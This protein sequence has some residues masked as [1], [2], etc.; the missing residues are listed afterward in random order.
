MRPVKLLPLLL[1]TA[2]LLPVTTLCR[3][4]P[5]NGNQ[6]Q[7]AMALLAKMDQLA[8]KQA[9]QVI[10]WRRDIHQHP[11]LGNR[12]F[13]TAEKIAAHLRSL[14]I[15]VKIGVGK[16]GVIG[17]LKGGH[18]GPVVALRADMDAL[19]I[20]E[21][22]ELAFKSVV[23]TGYNGQTTGVMHACGHDTHVA[24]LMG[25]A[26]IL[27][28]VK[29]DLRGSVKFIFQPCEEGPPAGEEGGAKL[30]VKEAALEN[31]AVDVIFG[32]H[33]A[34]GTPTGTFI[35]KPGSVSAENDIFRIVIKGKQSHGASPWLGVDPIVTGSQ[36]V[37]ALQTIVSRN[38]PLTSNAA[39]VTVG[40]FNAGNREN[41]IPEE[42]VL[43]GT[44][45]TL[46][47]AMRNTINKRINEIVDHIAASAGATATVNISMEDAMLVNNEQLTAE[48]LPTLQV[49]AGKEHTQL[50][51]A[52]LGAEDFAYFAQKVPGFFFST[53][54]LPPQMKASEVGHHTPGFQIDESSMVMGVKALCHLTLNYME[55]HSTNK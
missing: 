54:A 55:L 50:V 32:Q 47:T 43:I 11:E 22:N 52:G 31:P 23:T 36:I 28:A 6:Q 4:L 37:M 45:R 5:A 10:A 27:A 25:A 17:L 34:S 12:E 1:F 53:G 42:A 40:A 33:I 29:K 35:Y 21:I 24:M 41:I 39:V 51:P 8:E 48:M 2:L 46:D 20:T 30:M 15:E 18:P 44:V 16:T 38:M 3:Q 14:G 7:P 19:P 13:R 49:L 9:P 26:E